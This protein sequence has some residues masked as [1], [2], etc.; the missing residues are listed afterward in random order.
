[1]SNND[2][3]ALDNTGGIMDAVAKWVIA[4][5]GLDPT[6]VLWAYYGNVRPAAPYIWMT[7]DQI[8]PVGHD[9]TT[10]STNSLTV[11]LTVLSVD[12]TADTLTIPSHGL[13]NGDGPIHLASTVG[14]PAP[15]VAGTD[16]WVIYVDDNTIKLATSYVNT[17]G[18][19]PLGAG[20]PVTPIDLTTAGSGTIT[21]ASTPDTV[22]AGREIVKTAQG[23]REVTIGLECYGAEKS[24]PDSVRILT[25]V[26]AGIQLY[27]YDLDQAGFGVSDFGQ[28][29]SQN[30]VQLVQGSRGSILEPRATAQVVGYTASIMTGYET[31][32]ESIDA[33]IVLDSEGGDPLPAIPVHI[34]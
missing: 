19:Q 6:K 9:Y 4:T 27:L 15:L 22:P 29:Y 28:A 25:N 12:P 18:Q 16:Y 3:I 13:F 26:M 7:V 32:I 23:I 34:P 20:N 31:I 14:L 24:G 17:G 2:A 21:I 30:G 5:S 10:N 1:M 33:S 11:A 8:R